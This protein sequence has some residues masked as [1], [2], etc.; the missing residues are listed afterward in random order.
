[1][2]TLVLASIFAVATACGISYLAVKSREVVEDLP[3]QARRQ[4]ARQW[5]WYV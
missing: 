3:V 2:F 1:M 5:C 4:L